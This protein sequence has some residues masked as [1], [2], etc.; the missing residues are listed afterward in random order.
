[1]NI[2]EQMEQRELQ[3]LNPYASCSIRSKGRDRQETECDIRTVY[4]RDR[5][6]IVHCKSFRRMKDKTQVFL[7][8]QGII[9][10]PSDPYPGSFSDSQNR[11]KGTVLK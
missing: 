9:T 8:P 3:L 2:R 6:R 7:A 11:G 4:Q 10:E 5:D 1:M